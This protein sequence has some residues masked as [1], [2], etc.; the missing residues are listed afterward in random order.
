IGLGADSIELY[1]LAARIHEARGDGR[2]ARDWIDRALQRDPSARQLLEL[3]ERIVSRMHLLTGL[4]DHSELTVRL[5]PTWTEARER[6]VAQLLTLGLYEAAEP[7]VQAA[8]AQQPHRPDFHVQR[9][10]I[11]IE[12][13]GGTTAVRALDRA[14]ALSESASDRARIARL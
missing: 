5:H 3:R 9:A 12:T 4:Y 14:L 11:A 8:I 7:H 6:L 13:G 1:K 10:V 2:M